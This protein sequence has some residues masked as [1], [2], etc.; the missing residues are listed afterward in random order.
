MTIDDTT[1]YVGLLVTLVFAAVSIM[2]GIKRRLELFVMY[3]GVYALIA[4]DIVICIW[5]HEPIIAALY[6]TISSI[7]AIAAMFVIHARFND[8]RVANA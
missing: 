4:L 2:Y 3:G 8:K 7:A 1:R 6:L 5:I